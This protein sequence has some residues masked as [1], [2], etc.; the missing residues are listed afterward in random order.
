MKNK[1]IVSQGMPC[2]CRPR[3]ESVLEWTSDS[4][5]GFGYTKRSRIFERYPILSTRVSVLF[6]Q[7][8]ID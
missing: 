3:L 5:S 2:E 1:R 7:V 4:E 6:R 8:Y